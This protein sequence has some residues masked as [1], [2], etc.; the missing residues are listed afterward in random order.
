MALAAHVLSL[1]SLAAAAARPTATLTSCE[2]QYVGP[3]FSEQEGPLAEAYGS[4]TRVDCFDVVSIIEVANY[5][6]AD[7]A[8]ADSSAY[9]SESK[10]CDETS[11]CGVSTAIVLAVKLLSCSFGFGLAAIVYSSNQ[12][13]T[14]SLA[15]VPDAFV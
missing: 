15:C 14:A 13:A 4:L 11:S 2:A 5:Q 1:P 10:E 9:V 8:A 6:F 3:H 7:E 12:G